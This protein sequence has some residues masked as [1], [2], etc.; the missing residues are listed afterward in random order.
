M[1]MAASWIA[2]ARRENRPVVDVMREHGEAGCPPFGTEHPFWTGM[3][4]VE[5]ATIDD[6]HEIQAA[7]ETLSA[8]L[9]SK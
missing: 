5:L 2:K 8:E 3:A 7:S 6:L 9:K 1:T 4:E